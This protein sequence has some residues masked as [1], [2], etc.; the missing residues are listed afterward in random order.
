MDIVTGERP[1]EAG[2]GT[3]EHTL[4]G[5]LGD[6]SC[7][8]GLLDSHSSRAGDVTD[9]D[10]RT[11]ATGSVRLDPTVGCESIAVKA[12]TEVLHHVV[13]LGLTVDE[14]VKV[15]LLLDADNILN[16]LL[17]EALI[18]LSGDLT[19]GELVTLDTDLLGLG[20]GSNCGGG[21]DGE[22]EVSLLGSETL[23]EGRL[24]LVVLGLDSSLAVLDSLVVGALGGGAGLHGLGVGLKSLTHGSRAL[25]DGLGND[26]D[27]YTLLALSFHTV[28]C[29]V[30][31]GN[32]LDGEG[33]PVGNLSV[34]LLLGLEGVGSV[35]ERAGS[36]NNDTVL[37]ELL[38]GGL[39]G[40]DG[41]LEVGLPD[42][43][44]IDDTS[45]EDLAG[46][47]LVDDSV[48]LLGVADE[49]DVDTVDA[50]EGGEDIEVVDNVTEV[51]GED[52][53]GQ[54]ASGECLVG[55]LEGIL[56]LLGEVLD[57]DR[58]VNLDSLGTS[59]LELLQELDVYG[60]KLVEERD[61]VNGLATV[62]LTEV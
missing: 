22:L 2:D 43:A 1:P 20:E 10:R 55:R 53:L 19:L 42:V 23:R 18:L 25:S 9:N 5:L 3:C 17:N 11:D 15:K 56:D 29:F 49:V 38:D 21:E 60:H 58:L 41:T 44:A 16:L 33:E 52:D 12:L 34:E 32:L 62:G 39:N 51:G 4:H 7:V 8:L 57:E 27:L 13:T 47:E 28:T 37:A 36:G 26:G 31:L 35:E 30:Y 45:R 24:A 61:G 54:T 48:E 14:D 50:L 6:G 46:A 40:L 59:L